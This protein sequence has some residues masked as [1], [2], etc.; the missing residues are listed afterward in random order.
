[1]TKPRKVIP[2]R[3]ELSKF[4]AGVIEAQLGCGQVRPGPLAERV[5]DEH[6]AI[7]LALGRQLAVSAIADMIRARIKDAIERTALPLFPGLGD[8][9]PRAIA[10]PASGDDEPY[11]VA[12]IR[13]TVLEL[14]AAVDLL[15]RQIV[16]D[17]LRRDALR[18]VLLRCDE[19]GATDN[20]LVVDVV[21][22]KAA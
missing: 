17:A 19:A 21:A 6:P 10:V 3:R 14:R 1:V 15:T 7:V 11:Y 18:R 12:L 9:L 8:N 4:V 22:S 16:A 5:A 2:E 20:A 13:A